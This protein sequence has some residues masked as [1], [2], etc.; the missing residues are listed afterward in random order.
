[1]KI[2][3]LLE[4]AGGWIE[5]PVLDEPEL[6]RAMNAAGVLKARVIK[7]DG[8]SFGEGARVCLVVD[9]EQVFSGRVFTKRRSMPDVIEI[10]AYDE[11]RYLQNRDCCVFSGVSP[12][13]MLKQIAALVNLSVGDLAE[14]NWRCGV[15]VYDN[16]RY[17]D[18]LVDVLD[19]VL[20]ERGRHYTVI[21]EKG[22]LCLRASRDMS[23]DVCLELGAFAEYEYKTSIDENYANRVKLIY[24]DKRK[25]ARRQFV[26]EDREAI[27]NYGV[28]QYVHKSAAVEEENRANASERLRQLN[29]RGESLTVRRATGD[30]AVRGGS[31]VWVRM[32]L[33]DKVVDGEALVKSARHYFKSGVCL[34]DLELDCGLF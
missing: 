14:V 30:I 13:E 29:R 27:Q 7:C 5:P 28:L 24:E 18:M 4:S 19:G 9:G 15:R 26:V 11:L 23:C 2:S 10:V 21:A 32:N 31:I 12:K 6:I 1:M 17:I 3:I 33:G 8:L 20:A 34:M 22:R 16:R 25:A